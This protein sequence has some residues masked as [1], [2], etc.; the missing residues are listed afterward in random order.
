MCAKIVHPRHALMKIAKEEERWRQYLMCEENLL[1]QKEWI[2]KAYVRRLHRK[3]TEEP[4][5]IYELPTLTPEEHEKVKQAKENREAKR[6][7]L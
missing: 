5:S 4:P 2:L 7:Y 3:E 6:V 1:T